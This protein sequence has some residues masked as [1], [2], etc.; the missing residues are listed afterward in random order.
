MKLAVKAVPNARKNELLGWEEDTLSGPVLR[1][2]VAAPPLEGK[3]N[4]E[5]TAFLSKC[6]GLPK[7][8]ISLLNGDSGRIK[9]FQ[10]DAAE[11]DIHRRLNSFPGVKQPPPTGSIG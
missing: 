7:S 11:A 10:I 3:A 1:I 8:R 6:L 9:L 4:R 2:R 5:L